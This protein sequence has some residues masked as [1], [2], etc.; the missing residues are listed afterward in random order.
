HEQGLDNRVCEKLG[1]PIVEPDLS[2]WQQVVQAHKNP[3]HEVKIAMVGKY[4]DHSDAYKSLT[5]ALVHAGIQLRTQI[6]TRKVDSEELEKGHLDVLTDCHAI[7]VP[8]GFGERGIEGKILA[9]RYARENN[10]PYLGICLGMQ[11]AVIDVAVSVAGLEGAYST[12]FKPDTPHPVIALIT[13]WEDENG[14]KIYRG[15]DSDLG[16]TMRLGAQQ[17]RLVPGSR[18]HALYGQE[19]IKERHRHRY[20]FNNTYRQKL[21]DAGMKICG[22]SIDGNL[23]EMI[24]LPDHPWFVACQFHP[25]FTSTPRKGHPLFSGFIEAASHYKTNNSQQQ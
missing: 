14:E 2:D 13:E 23:V 22:T 7:L 16:G 15:A 6:R 3:Q 24:E 21:E 9:A 20:E 5:E 19:I 17:C 1:L 18:S 25:E 11:V 12:E 10:I 4:I 8:G